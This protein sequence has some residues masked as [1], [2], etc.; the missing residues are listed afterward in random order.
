MFP[1]FQELSSVPLCIFK[2]AE[3]AFSE[4]PTCHV[5][6]RSYMSRSPSLSWTQNLA[7]SEAQLKNCSNMI[8][9]MT[10]SWLPYVSALFRHS[11]TLAIILYANLEYNS[12]CPFAT[13]SNRCLDTCV[14][15]RYFFKRADLALAQS[16]ASCLLN[17]AIT[18]AA[19]EGSRVSNLCD[20]DSPANPTFSHVL[21][22]FTR[23]RPTSSPKSYM[24]S[25][26][27]K[28]S[29][30]FSTDGSGPCMEHSASIFF[31]SNSSC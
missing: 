11:I 19:S 12:F 10:F 26:T 18:S 29:T 6:F 1:S 7:H 31:V 21:L 15:K 9:S 16:P 17:L 30:P 3:L 24:R 22:K 28:V 8:H 14:N 25:F 4:A 13:S 23:K 5:F 27:L 20:Q 2:S